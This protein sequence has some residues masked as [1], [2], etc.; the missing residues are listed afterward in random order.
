MVGEREPPNPN[1]IPSLGFTSSWTRPCFG[2]VSRDATETGTV[3]SRSKPLL[4]GRAV[5][6]LLH[7]TGDWSTESRNTLL[8]GFDRATSIETELEGAMTARSR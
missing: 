5:T 4:E 7:R 6:A 1:I 3:G 8:D 2:I